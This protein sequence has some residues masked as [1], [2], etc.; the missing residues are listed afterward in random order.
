MKVAAKIEGTLNNWED[1]DKYWTAEMAIPVKDLTARG[2]S[3][4]PGSHWVVLLARYNYSVYLPGK[5]LTTALPF[6]KTAVG[7]SAYECW[8]ELRFEK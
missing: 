4:G 6:P 5:E 3:F 8:A 2:D 7:F 1:K